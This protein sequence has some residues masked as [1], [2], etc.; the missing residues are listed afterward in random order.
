V[1]LPQVGVSLSPD[2]TREVTNEERMQRAQDRFYRVVLRTLMTLIA[3]YALRPPFECTAPIDW[4]YGVQSLDTPHGPVRV[5]A[6]V[7]GPRAIEIR[8]AR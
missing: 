1:S 6:R 5:I 4:S 2:V 7:G 8:E 3:E